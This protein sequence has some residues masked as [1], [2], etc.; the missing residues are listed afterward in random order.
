MSKSDIL[1]AQE[2]W[3]SKQDLSGINCLHQSYH[4]YGVAT[5]DYCD[6]LVTGHP[7]GGVAILW[8]T[9]SRIHIW[10]FFFYK[11]NRC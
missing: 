6:G 3:Y 5:R 2:T 8:N 11:I 9:P 10:I 7:P 1:C 4:G